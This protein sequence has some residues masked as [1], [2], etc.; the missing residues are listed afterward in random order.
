MAVRLEAAYVRELRVTGPGCRENGPNIRSLGFEPCDAAVHR[1]PSLCF[2]GLSLW[3]TRPRLRHRQQAL[4]V[5]SGTRP[6]HR[7]LGA[8]PSSQ[9]APTRHD[10][11]PW[12]SASTSCTFGTRARRRRLEYVVTACRHRRGSREGNCRLS[13]AFGPFRSFA[14][15]RP[16]VI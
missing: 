6:D 4:A 16:H 8:L 5:R 11:L 1:A 3:S 14:A 12:P 10:D 7:R 9:R 2:G 15:A 13:L